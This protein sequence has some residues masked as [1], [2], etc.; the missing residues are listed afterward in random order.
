MNTGSGAVKI[1]ISARE[2]TTKDIDRALAPTKHLRTGFD[3]TNADLARYAEDILA[4]KRDTGQLDIRDETLMDE[5]MDKLRT[6][7]E[8]IR[9]HLLLR[10]R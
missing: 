7:G 5:I 2:S 1:L 3:N 9:G 10:K 6:G 4:K 8:G